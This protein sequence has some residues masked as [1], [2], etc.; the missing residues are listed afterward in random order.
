MMFGEVLEDAKTVIGIVG[1][2]NGSIATQ[3]AQ[4]GFAV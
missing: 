1:G 2:G 3:S 4:S